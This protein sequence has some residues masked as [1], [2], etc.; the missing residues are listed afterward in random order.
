MC[1]HLA[2]V[3]SEAFGAGAA[4]GLQGVLADAAVEAGL[5]VA[6]VDLVL[7]VG[8]GEAGAA[9]AG[10]AVDFVRAR[11][12]IEAGAEEEQCSDPSE[13]RKILEDL[14]LLRLICGR[15]HL[16]VSERNRMDR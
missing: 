9:A 7:A 3:P 14:F 11:P 8:A 4:E 12:S 1:W 13:V 2:A 16:I 15:S 10:V 5:R 6:L